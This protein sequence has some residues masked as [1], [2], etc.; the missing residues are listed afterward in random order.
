MPCDGLAE[1]VLQQIVDYKSDDSTV[2]DADRFVKGNGRQ[3]VK[4]RT[5]GWKLCV[6]WKDD[7]TSW[8]TFADPKESFP[9]Q[10][11]EYAVA[12]FVENEPAFAWWV[13]FI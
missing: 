1:L 3:H 4:R 2:L 5:K 8:E 7:S 10:V 11:A 12:Q 9:I 6:R 13:P